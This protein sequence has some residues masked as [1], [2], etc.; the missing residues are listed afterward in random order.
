MN[1]L[2]KVT[3]QYLKKNKVRT[4]VTIIG[5]ILSTAMF[6]AVTTSISSFQ[7]YMLKSEIDQEGAWEAIAY[8]MNEKQAENLAGNPEIKEM[9]LF[10]QFGYM[11]IDQLKKN[12]TDSMKCMNSSKPYLVMASIDSGNTSLINLTMIDGR[13]PEKENEILIPKHLITD[14]K[15]S[16]KQGDTITGA[17]GQRERNGSILWQE[18]FGSAAEDTE[19]FH[20]TG[21]QKTYTVVGVYE[22]L[23]YS[24]EPY[25]LP[26]YT[27]LCGKADNTQEAV[28]HAVFTVWHPSKL[29]E[30][31]DGLENKYDWH[32]DLLRI[33]GV[34][35]QDSFQ[36]VYLGLGIILSAI[37]MFGSIALIYN[38]FSISVNERIK[39]F[40]LLSSIGATKRQ[41]KRSVLFEACTVSLLGIP[42]G[43]LAGIFGMGVTFY[44]LRDRFTG[45][46]TNSSIPLT[47]DVKLWAVA[48]AAFLAFLTVL[49]SAA[50]PAKKAMK[51]PAIE[52]IRQNR[53][54]KVKSQK[55]KSLGFLYRLFGLEGMLADKNFKRNRK[56]YRATV[57]SLFVSIVLFI[58]ASSFVD[59][60]KSSITDVVKMEN[61][62]IIYYMS[63]GDIA[64]EFLVESPEAA[65]QEKIAALPSVDKV[66]LQYGFYQSFIL[67]EEALTKEFLEFGQKAGYINLVDEFINPEEKAV[68]FSF[69]F[70]SDEEYKQYLKKYGLENRG[71]FSNNKEALVFDNILIMSEEK[72]FSTNCFLEK[73]GVLKAA[74]FDIK[75][76]YEEPKEE[77]M[78][79]QYVSYPVIGEEKALGYYI[80]EDIERPLGISSHSISFVYPYSALEELFFDIEKGDAHFYI[81]AENNSLAYSEIQSMLF[82][83]GLDDRRLYNM[84][85]SQTFEKNLVLIINVFSYGFIVLISLIAAANVFN[86]ISTN[87]SLRQREFAMLESIGMTKKGLYRMLNYECILYGAKSILYGLPVSIAATWFIYKVVQDGYAIG[88]YIPISSIIIAVISVFLV[89]FVTMFY[90]AGKLKK[91][92]VVE[93]LKNEN[94]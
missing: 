61:Y 22:R 76:R 17:I 60:L 49:V 52:A 31:L 81:T 2:N 53:E 74:A 62:D 51:I 55:Y 39:Q 88:F 30:L 11:E 56:K 73:E 87:I 10:R 41:L 33:N 50:I 24:V 23:N 8:C 34:A 91:H 46:Y 40:G 82:K 58:S 36:R 86:T 3:L 83:N 54:I 47:I 93:T 29:F 21:P 27:V 43:I 48:A 32:S 6:T 63:Y 20:E 80:T 59:Y 64:E 90:A 15:V 78:K 42:F 7:T 13:M 45:I 57:I 25:F 66:S 71:Y 94:V 70:L 89:V 79:G 72:Y 19:T 69:S 26:G 68:S 84:A 85:Q 37:I 9:L 77:G 92:S 5:I 16:L 12:G 28:Q 38:A 1:I 4:I 44:L 35:R 75:N 65:L 18:P 67:K 14:G